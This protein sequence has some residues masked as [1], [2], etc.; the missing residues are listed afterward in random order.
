MLAAADALRLRGDLGRARSLVLR[1]GSSADALAA[2]IL[3]RA[4]D[5]ALA[6]ER[7]RRAL[8]EDADPTGRA[9][10]VL[11]RIALD[12]GDQGEA[13]RLTEGA[14]TAA[15]S[16]VAALVCAA[17][18]NM[19]GALAEITRGEALATRAEERARLA[20]VR[21]YVAHGSDPE[22]TFAAYGAAVDHAVRSGAIVEE[23]TYRTGEAAAAVSLGELGAA[24]AT[25]RRAALL[26]EHLGRP[27]LA[28]P[29]CSPPPPR[30]P[31]RARSTTRS[32][33]RPRRR[34]GRATAAI[35][36]PR[37][38]RT[39]PSP[40]SPSAAIPRASPPPSAPSRC[41]ATPAPRTPSAPPRASFATARPR[42]PRTPRGSPR[43]ITSPANP[44]R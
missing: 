18:G 25:A 35:A 30:T 37:P 15:V 40:T 36:A 1:E 17:R 38:T 22:G 5:L 23:A 8:A 4:G 42:S 3:R 21:G 39:G 27:E 24:I 28:A 14:S 44:R 2:D 34:R 20:A 6:E 16:E 29:P 31:P 43:S 13:A 33:P 11:A 32:A 10:A 7:A 9:C 26:W 12:R 41:S 19:A